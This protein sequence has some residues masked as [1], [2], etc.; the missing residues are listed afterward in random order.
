MINILF[1]I[2]IISGGMIMWG[3]YE[4]Y[5]E[6]YEYTSNKIESIKS[7]N[8]IR[9]RSN[10]SV[11]SVIKFAVVSIYTIVKTKLI[12]SIQSYMDGLNIISRG[13]HIYEINLFI[14][15]KF[16]KML[17]ELKQGPSHVLFVT[18]NECNDITDKVV[19]Y[20]TYKL[21][22]VTPERMGVEELELVMCNG[23]NLK[24]RGDN[25][26]L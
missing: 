21:L 18:D 10:I 1:Y 6:I 22:D 17:I 3:L 14:R 20:Y 15:G 7:L 2:G 9:K 8:K 23:E 12:M 11:Y 4:N 26:V 25:K 19:P 24:F 5:D 13:K 16:V